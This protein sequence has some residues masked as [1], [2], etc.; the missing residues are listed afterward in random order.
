M[1]ERMKLQI[2][3]AHSLQTRLPQKRLNN[4]KEWDE[5]K[6]ERKKLEKRTVTLDSFERVCSDKQ[7]QLFIP[8]RNYTV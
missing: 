7:V 4:E 8:G 6:K 2:V 3:I 1:N 5:K